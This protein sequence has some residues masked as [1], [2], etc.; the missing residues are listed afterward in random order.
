MPSTKEARKSLGWV[1]VGARGARKSLWGKGVGARV[2]VSMY[3]EV[4]INPGSHP[5]YNPPSH[6]SLE[7]L[8]VT[9]LELTKH[10][11]CLPLPS[12]CYVSARCHSQLFSEWGFRGSNRPSCSHAKHFIN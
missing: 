10:W 1:R 9:G 7:S 12:C 8:S 2:Y 5:Q 3:T 4:K 11:P 6:L